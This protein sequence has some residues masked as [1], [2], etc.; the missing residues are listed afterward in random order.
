MKHYLYL[1]W[2]SAR[3][4]LNKIARQPFGSL[5]T[6]LMLS[7]ALA[8]PLSLYLTVS[9]IQE[10]AGRLT[11]TPQITLFMEQSAEEADLAAVSSTLTK[12]PRIQ[13][14]SFVGKNRH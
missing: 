12:H 14:F 3:Q 9:S 7:I 13:S 1:N 6:L 5:L 2:Q 8:L 10:W 4:A 11:A